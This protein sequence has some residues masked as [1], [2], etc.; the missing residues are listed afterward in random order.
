MDEQQEQQKR[1]RGIPD[2]ARKATLPNRNLTRVLEE[3][4]RQAEEAR[5]RIRSQWGRGHRL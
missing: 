3:R 2:R 1:F 4:E 5:Q